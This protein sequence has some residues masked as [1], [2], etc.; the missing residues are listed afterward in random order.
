[1]VHIARAIAELR[2]IS[3]ES[4]AELTFSNAGCFFTSV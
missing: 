1:L 4:L 2:G 3:P